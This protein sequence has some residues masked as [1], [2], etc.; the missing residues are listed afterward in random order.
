MVSVAVLI[1]GGGLQNMADVARP[2]Q[3]A[4]LVKIEPAKIDFGMQAVG[5]PSRPRT[6][7][8]TNVSNASVTI[9]DITASGIDFAET[10]NC[11][12]S[13]APGSNCAIQVT[14]TPAVTG[15]RMGTIIITDSEPTSPRFLVLTGTGE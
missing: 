9:R 5:T 13:L 8:L 11:Q 15:P 6:A 10:D 12:G 4:P 7:T 3:S 2:L 14:F 1:V